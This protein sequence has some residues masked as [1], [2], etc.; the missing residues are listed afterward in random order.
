MFNSKDTRY[1]GEGGKG[2]GGYQGWRRFYHEK[3]TRERG[4]AS[5]V[6]LNAVPADPDLFEVLIVGD[7]SM[8]WRAVDVSLIEG[9]V[10]GIMARLSG[11]VGHS[12]CAVTIIAAVDGCLAG[13]FHC[14]AQATLPC[15]SCVDHEFR[16][17]AHHAPLEAWSP[18][19][20]CRCIPARRACEPVGR[21]ADGLATELNGEQV[22]PQLRWGEVDQVAL[23]CWDY[24]RPDAHSRRGGDGHGEICS[25]C[26]LGDDAELLQ[27]VDGRRCLW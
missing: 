17:T 3:I 7:V 2:G 25:P 18:R 13:P 19:S 1:Y 10:D 4:T 14:D 9:D 5:T 27:G 8:E 22:L 16:W 23:V 26:V 24:V 21:G 11:E 6:G 12:T 20:H 15:L